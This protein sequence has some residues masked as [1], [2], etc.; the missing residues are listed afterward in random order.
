VGQATRLIEQTIEHFGRIHARQQCRDHRPDEADRR[1]GQGR[2]TNLNSSYTVKAVRFIEQSSGKIIN[3]S[4]FVSQAG[5]SG[6]QTTR[7]RRPA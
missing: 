2:Q 6:R 7:R 5:T 3:I 4:S 1:V